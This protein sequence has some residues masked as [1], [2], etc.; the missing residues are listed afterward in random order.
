MIRRQLD[1]SGR[2]VVEAGDGSE[3]LARA[4]E[5]RPAA[6]ILDL[7]MPVMDGFEFIRDFRADPAFES[8]PVVVVPAKTLD[9][10]EREAL[11]SHVATVLQKGDYTRDNLLDQI[12]KALRPP[13]EAEVA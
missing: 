1:G 6:V 13:G 7:M 3:A 5:R 8:T 12:R 2:A 11:R 4:R 10:A 9:A